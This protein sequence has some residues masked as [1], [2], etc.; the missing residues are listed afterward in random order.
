MKKVGYGVLFAAAVALVCGTMAW[1]AEGAAPAAPAATPAPAAPAAAAPA[2]PAK[3]AAPAASNAVNLTITGKNYCPEKA[4]R[5]DATPTR[6]TEACRN[7]LKISE[8]K[9]E[10]GTV[11]DGLKGATVYYLFSDAA[12]P[13]W[14]DSANVDKMVTVT[15]TLYKGERALD[16][17]SFKL[18]PDAKEDFTPAAKKK[19]GDDF[20]DFDYSK[21]GGSASARR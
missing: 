4:L 9:D 1:A 16:V 11:I 18:A 10:K 20:G 21:G 6:S 8:A 14:S 12:K 13:L 19:G 7:A 3:P 15:G 5:G 17:K 2:A